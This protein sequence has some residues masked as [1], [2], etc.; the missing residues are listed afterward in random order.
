VILYHITSYT[1][2]QKII[3]DGY[4]RV[5]ESNIRMDGSGP[6]VVW[7]TDNQE[8]EQG[9][10]ATDHIPDHLLPLTDTKDAVRFTVSLPEE[11]PQHWTSW[12]R[13]RGISEFWYGALARSGGDP[14]EWWVI[15]RAIPKREWLRVEDIRPERDGTGPALPMWPPA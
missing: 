9:W 11:E 12:S 5:T 13:K 1:R 14:T 3:R 2:A 10:Q 6:R 7:L 15:T 4:L 8:P